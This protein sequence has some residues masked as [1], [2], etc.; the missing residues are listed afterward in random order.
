MP[1]AR[2]TPAGE[3]PQWPLVFAV[4]VLALGAA[5]NRKLGN[6]V[7]ALVLAA[8]AVIIP[9]VGF[10]VRSYQ[11]RKLPPRIRRVVV[12]VDSPRGTIQLE[13]AKYIPT[14]RYG[15]RS[16]DE[17]A[18]DAWADGSSATEATLSPLPPLPAPSPPQSR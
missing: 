7:L 3:V 18:T 17:A 10:C 13:S 4:C 11:R 14:P 5:S 15:P 9:V 6:D 16:S 8:A 1:K 12:E 2:N